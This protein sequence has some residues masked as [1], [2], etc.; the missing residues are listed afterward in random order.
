MKRKAIVILEDY[1]LKNLINHCESDPEKECG[2]FLFGKISSIKSGVIHCYV[3]GIYSGYGMPATDNR[4]LFTPQY[5][6]QARDWAK[7]QNLQM[8]GFYHSHGMYVPTPSDQDLISYNQ[9]FPREGLS[10]IYSPSY[11][12]HS[13]YICRDAILTGNNIYVKHG[14]NYRLV[15]DIFDHENTPHKRK[16]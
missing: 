14:D 7:T 6:K 2:G 15:D 13:D 3:T 9:L 16:K 5:F 12:I 8:I 4:F 10:L 1:V 11:G